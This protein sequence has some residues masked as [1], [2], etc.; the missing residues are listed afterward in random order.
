MQREGLVH[1]FID[2]IKLTRRWWYES[3]SQNMTI[4][5]GDLSGVCLHVLWGNANANLPVPF[6]QGSVVCTKRLISCDPN[7][8]V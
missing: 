2:D 5:C 7:L 1:L 8:S 6:E 3:D 4:K